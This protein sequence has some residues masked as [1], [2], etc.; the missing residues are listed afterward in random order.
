MK[1][2]KSN[3]SKNGCSPVASDCVT[4]NGPDLCCI[5]E[6][7]GDTLSSVVFKLSQELCYH[8]ALLDLTVLDLDGLVLS[9]DGTRTPANV[10]QAI[11]NK[12]QLP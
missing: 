6:C 7:D 5:T 4:W 11:I 10:L 9:G 2:V 1:P 8:R 12:I 3:L